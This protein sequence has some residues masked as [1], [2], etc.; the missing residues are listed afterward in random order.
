MMFETL[1]RFVACI[2]FTQC[3][4]AC[5]GTSTA[6]NGGT[7]S[8]LGDGLSLTLQDNGSD[9]LTVTDNGAFR[10]ANS[11]PNDGTYNVVVLTR[12]AGQ[13][14]TVANGSGTV[15]SSSGSVG[16]V[17]INCGAPA[18][19]GGTVSG[20]APG[21]SLILSDGVVLLPIAANGAFAFPGT[22]LAGLT[23]QVT[24]ATQPEGETCMVSNETGTVVSNVMSDVTVTCN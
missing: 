22:V 16:G 8:G 18:S 13:E 20:L 9:S 14:C 2:I 11:I 6:S 7:V 15:N 12:P 21:T 4:A 10:F 5:W 19:V 3:V 23:Y 24:V 1:S 17:L